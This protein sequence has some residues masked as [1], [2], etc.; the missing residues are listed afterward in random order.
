MRKT[1]LIIIVVLAAILAG[2]T[3]YALSTTKTGK[4]QTVARTG[5]PAFPDL[6]KATPELEQR[7]R[8]TSAKAREATNPAKALGELA[9]LYQSNSYSAEAKQALSVLCE[10]DPKN[11]RWP[12]FL[13]RIAMENRDFVELEKQLK[14][15]IRISPNYG[16]AY[17]R[18]GDLLSNLERADEARG[19][20]EQRLKLLPGDPLAS[21]ALAGLDA[22]T[23]NTE[24]AITRLKALL[25]K[26]PDLTQPN[27]MLAELLESVGDR[28]GALKHFEIAQKPRPGWE[29]EDAWLTEMNEF[30]FDPRRLLQ[31]GLSR[32]ENGWTDQAVPFLEDQSD[33]Q[34]PSS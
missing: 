12:Y 3:W 34:L 25:E 24:S 5:V 1:N 15:T 32:A 16:P 17:L 4:L 23:G 10:I 8:D 13:A 30:C 9:M 22:N 26:H 6:S 19:Y 2:G 21:F 29:E 7:L 28:E 20:Y 18:M 27:M 11:G 33:C 31:L 14:E